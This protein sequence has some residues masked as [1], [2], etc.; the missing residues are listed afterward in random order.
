MAKKTTSK[1]TGKTK[2]PAYVFQVGERVLVCV[3]Q[4][5]PGRI[6]RLEGNRATVAMEGGLLAQ[7]QVKTADLEPMTA[8][9]AAD[10]ANMQQ[11]Q[12]AAQS[13]LDAVRQNR[14]KGEDV[15]PVRCPIQ[16]DF[17]AFTYEHAYERTQSYI[18][19]ALKSGLETVRIVH[20]HGTGQVRRAVEQALK[21]HPRVAAYHAVPGLAVITVNLR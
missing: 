20:G 5:A 21:T 2:K 6:E 19:E 7:M 1:T 16:I 15:A 12:A 17:H 3:W 18:D 11:L 10:L 4:N 9:L 14:N 8:E 13:R